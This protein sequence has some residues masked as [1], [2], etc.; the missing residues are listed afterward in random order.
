MSYIPGSDE[1]RRQMMDVIGVKSLDE[2]FTDVPSG[3][4]L[5]RSLDLPKPMA[6]AELAR[7]LTELSEKNGTTSRY[8]SFLGAGAYNHYIP[9]IVNH[10]I[11]RSEF[12]TAYTP[13]QAEISQGTLRA[14]YEFQTMI[15]SLTGMDVANA[16][17]YDG[18]TAV[19]EAALMA[20]SSTRRKKI[21]VSRAVHPEYRAVLDT[22]LEANGLQLTEVAE[23]NGSTSL[24]DL[25]DKLDN[26]TAALIIQY[27]NFLGVVEGGNYLADLIH[28]QG[29][30][31]VVAA[32]LVSLGILKAPGEWGADIV[33]GEGQSLGNP[34]SFGGPYVGFFATREKLVRRMPGRVVGA[35]VDNRG[36]R[37]YVL[38]LQARE[39]HIRRDKATSNICSNEALCALATTIHLAALGKKGLKEMAEICLHKAHYAYKCLLDSGVA[40]TSYSAPFFMEFAVRTQKDPAVINRYLLQHGF[41]GGLDLGRFYPERQGEMLFC[42]TEQHTKEQI[43]KLVTLIGEVK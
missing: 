3:V 14:I 30:L 32:E 28:R 22:Y 2:L 41:I 31:L 19:A 38:T 40:K 39:Q 16:S 7:H 12:Y 24:E 1:D 5:N 37:A 25:E 21:L 18:A 36:R 11:G 10:I 29:A 8:V 43:D 17:M 35:T 4:K 13:Y 34:L 9:S 26:Q 6:E 33:V 42:V 15:C 20:C 27:P 23:D